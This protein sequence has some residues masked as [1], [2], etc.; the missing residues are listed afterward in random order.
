[1][2]QAESSAAATY[3]RLLRYLRPH[4]WII[5]AALVPAA[6]YAVLGTVVPLLMSV[7]IERL[8]DVVAQSRERV[9][10]SAG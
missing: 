10:D 2:P 7:V 8:K 3:R 4:W 1:M 6:I 9:A 5:V